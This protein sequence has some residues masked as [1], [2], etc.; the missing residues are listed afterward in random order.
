MIVALPGLFFLPFFGNFVQIFSTGD[1]WHEMSNLVSV[2]NLSSVYHPL[3]LPR[4]W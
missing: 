2:K 1:D 4:A 3:N